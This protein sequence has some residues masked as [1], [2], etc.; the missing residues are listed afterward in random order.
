MVACE[1]Q[2]SVH[3]SPIPGCGRALDPSLQRAPKHPHVRC[4]RVSMGVHLLR[5][6][7]GSGFRACASQ[8]DGLTYLLTTTRP[9]AN[10]HNF[11]VEVAL[12]LLCGFSGG[13]A[14]LR[15]VSSGAPPGVECS[16][17]M[18]SRVA[19]MYRTWWR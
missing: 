6:R 17:V 9:D 14:G 18:R 10:E 19:D 3:Q 8:D 15:L 5:H 12:T 11:Y 1:P 2:P 4:R 13:G 16:R 7:C